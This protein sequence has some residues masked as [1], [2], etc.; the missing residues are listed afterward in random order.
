MK[1]G[2]TTIRLFTSA[3][4]EEAKARG[5]ALGLP[6]VPRGD[7]LEAMAEETGLDGFLIYGKR[8]PY[9]WSFGEEY[10]FHVGTAALRTQQLAKGNGDRLCSLLPA[11]GSC[12]VLDCTFGQAG[13]STT[14]SW[15]LAGRGTVT[16]LEKSTALY[17]IGRAGIAS[18]VDK[19][20]SLTEAVRRIRLIHEDFFSFLEKAEPKSYDVIY[21]DPMFRHPV[22]REVND[23]EAFRRAASYDSL[24]EE[25]L[26]LA[27]RAARKK[28]IV[29]ER[30]FSQL[31]K[32]GPWTEVFAKKGQTTAYGVIAISD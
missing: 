18:Y 14:M 19:N 20:P 17:E 26:A 8:L 29:K 30:P 23:M 22:K 7:T 21:F 13:D 1:T 6:Y 10:R 28:V 15:Y 27:I 32:T 24:S 3:A 2:V 25:V 12:D 16:A 4:V 11:V 5:E 9:F 31:F